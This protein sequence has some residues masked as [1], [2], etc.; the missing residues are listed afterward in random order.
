MVASVRLDRIDINILV[1]LQADGR[2]T[3]V[4]LAD[5]VGLS[6]SPCLQRVKRLEAA[7]YITSF[8]ARL[9]LAKMMESVTV[10]TE[11]TLTDHHR[12]DFLRF[13]QKIRQVDEVME[14]HLISGGYDYLLRFITRSIAHYQRV[15]EALIEDEIG[16]EKY[17]SYIV[18]K[19]PINKEQLPLRTLMEG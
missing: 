19:T 7:G 5:A 18:I 10:F 11:I 4:H 12:E 1:Q 15:M 2:M 9:N 3:N 6:P 17:F 8:Q 14:C 16:I 13:E